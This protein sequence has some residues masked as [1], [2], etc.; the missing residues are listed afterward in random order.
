MKILVICGSLRKQ[1]F[2]RV[3][4]DIAYNYAKSKYKDVQLLDLGKTKL[5][6]FMGFEA[7]YDKATND[8]VKLVESSDVFIIGSPVYNGVFSS[9]LKN[10]FEF[11][12]YKALEGKTAGFILMSGS[13]ISYLQVQGQLISMMNYF[14]VISN[15]RAVFVSQESFDG[16]KLKDKEIEQRI[17]RIV[18]ETASMK[19]RLG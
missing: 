10:L 14:R 19:Q 16:Q 5:E 13:D 2:T 17:K 3:L 1:S 8:T 4:T 18:D 15:P 11:V 12:N 6:N 9:A 7:R